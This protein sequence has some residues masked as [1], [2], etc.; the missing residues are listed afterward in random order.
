MRHTLDRAGRLVKAA[1]GTRTGFFPWQTTARLLPPRL[2]LE[3]CGCGFTAFR[4]LGAD[5][6]IM[7][8]QRSLPSAIV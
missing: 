4:C 2:L 8:T 7:T 5:A 3:V 6:M 1:R